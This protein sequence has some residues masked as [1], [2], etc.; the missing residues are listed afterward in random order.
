MIETV[1]SRNAARLG[2]PRHA[3]DILTVV[4][5]DNSRPAGN[6]DARRAQDAGEEGH[7]GEMGEA[8]EQ[9]VKNA[10]TTQLTFH[11]LADLFPPLEGDDFNKLVRDIRARGLIHPVVAHHGVVLDG[12]NRLR[13]CKELGITPKFVEFDALGLKCS[14]EEYIW[15]ANIERRHLSADQRAMIAVEFADGLRRQARERQKAGLKKGQEKPVV[16]ISP[17]RGRTRGKPRG[18]PTH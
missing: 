6:D 13:A 16:V 10:P 14:P 11:P 2:G 3:F 5:T 17:Q 18:A 1:T 12:R 4:Q 8:Q 9:A 15:S 7:P